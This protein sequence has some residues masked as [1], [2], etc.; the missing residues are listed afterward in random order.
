ML[1]GK[2]PPAARTGCDQAGLLKVIQTGRQLGIRGTPYLFLEGGEPLRGFLDAQRLEQRFK[3]RG[4]PSTQ[5]PG[6]RPR[7]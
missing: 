3:E 1:E 6:A 5:P 4:Q 7:T 2:A